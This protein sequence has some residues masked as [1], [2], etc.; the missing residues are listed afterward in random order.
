GSTLRNART[1]A[2][3]PCGDCVASIGSPQG[4]QRPFR[5]APMRRHTSS[6]N[7]G[8]VPGSDSTGAAM[9][10]VNR[11]AE[12]PV[13]IGLAPVLRFNGAP[14]F[15]SNHGQA[16][17]FNVN[18]VNPPFIPLSLNPVWDLRRQPILPH[19]RVVANETRARTPSY[20]EPGSRTV[21]TS[22]RTSPAIRAGS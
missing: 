17:Q 12:E 9:G 13:L 5:P 10:A 11:G 22:G 18:A 21:I 4:G 8:S 1:R 14:G 15:P 2:R 16:G 20:G 19:H 6:S 7:A 3:G